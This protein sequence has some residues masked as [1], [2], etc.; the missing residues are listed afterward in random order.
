MIRRFQRGAAIWGTPAKRSTDPNRVRTLY[1]LRN[2]RGESYLSLCPNTVARAS[3]RRPLSDSI[4]SLSVAHCTGDRSRSHHGGRPNVFSLS[5]TPTTLVR[6]GRAMSPYAVPD[7]Q[8][9]GPIQNSE[10]RSR[11][12]S[13]ESVGKPEED[14]GE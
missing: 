7:I 13:R 5:P 3:I 9:Q 12:P 4:S 11:T 14:R 10:N 8:E 2:V 1:R 6:L